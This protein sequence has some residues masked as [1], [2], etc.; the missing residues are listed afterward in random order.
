MRG[1]GILMMYL[2]NYEAFIKSVVA[3]ESALDNS[4]NLILLSKTISG[5][6]CI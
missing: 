4:L 1:S 2:I 3:R 6:R 5:E